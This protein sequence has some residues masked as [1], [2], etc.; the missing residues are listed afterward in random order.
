MTTRC[1]QKVPLSAWAPGS[2]LP[3]DQGASDRSLSEVSEAAR[4]Q[5]IDDFIDQ[6]EEV[7]LSVSNSGTRIRRNETQNTLRTRRGFGQIAR[8]HKAK[9]Y[10]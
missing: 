3:M 4:R 8:R 6:L 1:L 5:E 10:H 7:G 2:S 9:N